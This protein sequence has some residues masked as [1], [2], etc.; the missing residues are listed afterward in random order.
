MYDRIL[1]PVDGSDEAKRAAKRGIEL[2]R[3][4]DAA[5]DIVHVVERRSRRLARTDAETAQLRERGDRILA[6]IEALASAV[7]RPVTTT[8]TEGTPAVRIAEHAADRDASL[9]VIGKQGLTGLGKRLLGGVTEGVLQRSDVPV[10]VVP[11]GDRSAEDAF[12]YARVL[13]PTD[14]SESAAA[15]A[16]HGATV[17]RRYG[18]TVHVLS[19]VDLQ[20]AGGAFNAGGLEKSFVERLEAQG[21][22][23]VDELADEIEGRDAD[24][25]L[26]TDVVRTTSFDGV[27]AGIREYV[28]EHDVDI[29]VMG[30]HGR[31]NLR[32]Q[33]LGSVT[34]TVLR[35]VDIPILVVTRS[36]SAAAVEETSE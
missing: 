36:E 13:V 26:E 33:L 5:V 2:A 6:E 17:A 20:A 7:D 22:A 4:F 12:D 16:P 23:A 29:V 19:V 30:S 3:T 25:E 28:A 32:R 15:A 10:L 11:A 18:A 1:L 8:L 27:A 21:M 35:T 31:S 34:A 14:G 24:L 9:I